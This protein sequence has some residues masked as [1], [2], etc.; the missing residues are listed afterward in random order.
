M[1]V[2]QHGFREKTALAA[3]RLD[4]LTMSDYTGRGY[5]I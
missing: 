2:A 1:Q 5:A 4:R 3:C